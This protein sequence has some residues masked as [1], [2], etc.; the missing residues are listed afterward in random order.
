MGPAVGHCATY[1]SSEVIDIGLPLKVAR[2]AQQLPS[3]EGG[4]KSM[5]A[6][7]CARMCDTGNAVDHGDAPED[8]HGEL[9]LT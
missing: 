2:L 1:G 3:E 7:L 4:L 8:E 9:D 5:A 6:Y